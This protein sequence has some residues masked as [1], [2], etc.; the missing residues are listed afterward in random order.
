MIPVR[1]GPI[2]E[3]SRFVLEVWSE[4]KKYNGVQYEKIN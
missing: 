4:M 1:D 3:L 2:N